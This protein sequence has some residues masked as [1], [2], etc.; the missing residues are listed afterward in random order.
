MPVEEEEEIFFKCVVHRRWQLLFLP[1]PTA[2]PSYSYAL[3]ETS[4]VVRF[5]PEDVLFR[6]LS[7]RYDMS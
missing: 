6:L 1:F 2:Y 5:A 4:Q 3:F 7:T